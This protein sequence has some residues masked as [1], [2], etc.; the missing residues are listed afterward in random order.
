MLCMPNLIDNGFF[1]PHT[2]AKGV[3]ILTSASLQDYCKL[4]FPHVN[5]S[6][7]FKETGYCESVNYNDELEAIAS[8]VKL[9]PLCPACPCSSSSP[10]PPPHF[11]FIIVMKELPSYCDFIFIWWGQIILFNLFPVSCSHPQNCYPSPTPLS[12]T[13]WFPSL[14][15]LI[16][17][18]KVIWKL[19]SGKASSMYFGDS[20]VAEKFVKFRENDACCQ[21]CLYFTYLFQAI[22]ISLPER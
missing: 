2:M 7:K 11:W 13:T 15:A 1:I 17:S 22:Y 6:C 8:A 9:L 10:P 3:K 5:L 4:W 20:K 16:K 21:N 12:T 18:E 14:L 19:S